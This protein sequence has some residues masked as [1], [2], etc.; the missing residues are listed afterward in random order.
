[1]GNVQREDGIEITKLGERLDIGLRIEQ[2]TAGSNRGA[3]RC[4]RVNL[5]PSLRSAVVHDQK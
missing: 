1:M 4:G 5:G 2:D 3:R